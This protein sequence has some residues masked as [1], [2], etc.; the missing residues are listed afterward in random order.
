VYYEEI[1]LRQ[2]ESQPDIIRSVRAFDE[3]RGTCDVAD[4]DENRCPCGTVSYGLE[5]GGNEEELFEIDHDTGDIHLTG[6]PQWTKNIYTLSVYAHNV[7][8]DGQDAETYGRK[9]YTTVVVSVRPE[10]RV[11]PGPRWK[12]HDLLG[13]IPQHHRTR[14][15]LVST[16]PAGKT[17][18]ELN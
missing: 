15:A 17:L 5:R 16:G 7:V 18:A 14:R 2:G 8:P 11:A 13:R 6:S 10:E 9:T 3:D 1:L 12:G 4:L